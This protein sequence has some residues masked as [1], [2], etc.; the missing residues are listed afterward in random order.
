MK[1][2]ALFL[3]LLITAPSWVEPAQT[4]DQSALFEKAHKNALLANEGF[5]RCA[6]YVQGW[7]ALADPATGLIPRNDEQ[8]FWN[9]KDSA[10]DNYPFMVLTSYY[11]NR[12]LYGGVMIDML[13]TEKRLTSRVDNLPD[14]F[15]FATQDFLEEEIDMQTILFGASEY[16]KDGLLPLMEAKG[17]TPWFERL[18]ELMDD[19]WKHASVDT[20]FGSI[21]STN[22]ELNGEMLQALSRLYYVTG[23]EKYLEYAIR[24]GDYYLLGENHPT[25]DFEYL[26][27]RDHGCEVVSG[28]CELYVVTHFVKPEKK[29]QYQPHLYEM[30]DRILKIGRN[31]HG[32]FYNGINP[33]TGEMIQRRASVPEADTFGYTLNGFY[34]VYLIDGIA[35]YRDAVIKA[36]SNLNE[37]YRSHN[38]EHGSSDGYADAI[39]SALNLYNREPIPSTAEWI[40]SEMQVMWGK[41][42]DSGIIEGWHGD[43]NFARTT[44]MYN[45]WK[46]QGAYVEPWREDVSIGAVQHEQTLYLY[47]TA[48]QP[49]TGRIVLDSARHRDNLNLPMDWPRINQFQEWFTIDAD[50]SYQV[51]WVNTGKTKKLSGREFQS[52]SIKLQPGEDLKLIIRKSDL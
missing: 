36:L 49:W 7:L 21:V 32:L 43:G 24:L 41:Q 16:I 35:R 2:S 27:L 20:P 8:L 15:D 48:E 33:Q 18:V 52:Q 37:H 44:I 46:T 42:Q 38:W 13:E 11:T 1:F 28:L 22:T 26:R 34:A 51:E 45:L 50:A 39:E 12:E 10:A 29:A 30:L 5:R 47:L 17:Q 6:H 14:T 9:A 31:E 25:R 23:E 4:P 40:D 19:S 3:V